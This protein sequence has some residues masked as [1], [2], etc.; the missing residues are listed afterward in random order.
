MIG[1]TSYQI[2]VLCALLC[3][4]GCASMH[5]PYAICD[6]RFLCIIGL[7]RASNMLF[8]CICTFYAITM[9][10][11]RDIRLYLCLV[12]AAWI[13][14]AFSESVWV[15]YVRQSSSYLVMD[16]FAAAVPNNLIQ[17]VIL[18]WVYII[19]AQSTT[20]ASMVHENSQWHLQSLVVLQWAC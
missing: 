9:Y 5:I 20:S 1:P 17:P 13:F 18:T 14:G 3:I 7:H 16:G 2:W 6:F 15:C 4:V 12:E 8:I 10:A 11:F 19:A